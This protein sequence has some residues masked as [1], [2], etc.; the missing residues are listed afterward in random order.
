MFD[1][2]ERNTSIGVQKDKRMALQ[3]L[4]QG[5][6]EWQSDNYPGSMFFYGSTDQLRR[7]CDLVPALQMAFFDPG[8]NFGPDHESGIRID[9]DQMDL[10][11]HSNLQKRAAL[12][13]SL[14]SKK[15]VLPD[16]E[17]RRLVGESVLK[18]SEGVS[19]EG[20]Y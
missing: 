3:N 5:R 18:F 10:N 8:P 14:Y 9:I 12:F 15:E 16:E 1:E 13:D 20:E 17:V 2:A 19:A 7:D 4:L 11:S 6:N